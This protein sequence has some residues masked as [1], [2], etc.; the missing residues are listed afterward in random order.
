MK[1][2]AYVFLILLCSA[3]QA[4]IP[5]DEQILKETWQS[6]SSHHSSLTHFTAEEITTIAN[7]WGKKL[8]KSLSVQGSIRNIDPIIVEKLLILLQEKDIQIY[9]RHG[10]QQRTEQVRKLPSIEQKIEMMRLEENLENPLTEESLSEWIE[11]MIIWKYLQEKTGRSQVLESSKNRRAEIPAS[12]LGFALKTQLHFNDALDCVNYPSCQEMSNA[13][14]L[15]WLPDGSLPWK[16]DKVDA[17][18]GP[19]TYERITQEMEKLLSSSKDS[20]T[21]YFAFTHTQQINAIA[22][23]SDL[24]IVRLGN[25][26]FILITDQHIEM[27]TEG[28][29]RK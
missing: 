10:E 28:F 12:A 16:R 19:G 1:K 22:A 20:N 23:A 9:I 2:H 29:Y 21:M 6:F 27:F 17:I 24:P 4:K 14:I 25:F 13:E 11:G 3:L 26:G 15:K 18:I 5:H 7:L 8:A